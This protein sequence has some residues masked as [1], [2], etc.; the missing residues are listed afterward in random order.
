MGICIYVVSCV[1]FSVCAPTFIRCY[2]S[3]FVDTFAARRIVSASEKCN[4]AW[5]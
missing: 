4:T 3:T 2:I 5:I 1:R